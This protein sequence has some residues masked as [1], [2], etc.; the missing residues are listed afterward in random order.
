MNKDLIARFFIEGIE[1]G[2]MPD[3]VTR[4]LASRLCGIR[5]AEIRQKNERLG[6]NG[7]DEFADEIRVGPIARVPEMAN[8]QHYE[9]PSDFFESRTEQ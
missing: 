7:V 8:D 2:L 6:G 3:S 9:L 5:L 4:R 1:R